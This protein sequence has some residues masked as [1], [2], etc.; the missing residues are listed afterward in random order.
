MAEAAKVVL[1]D[2]PVVINEEVFAKV[3]V[4]VVVPIVKPLYVAPTNEVEVAPKAILV[5]PIVML[6]LVKAVFGMLVKDA[7][8]PENK[9]A[10]TVPLVDNEVGVIL[11]K[12]IVNAGV[13]VAVA[14]VAVIPLLAAAVETEVTVPVP[15][16]L[17]IQDLVPEVVDESTYPL[18]EGF[19]SDGSNPVI[20]PLKVKLPDPVIDPDKVKPLTVPVPETLVTVPVLVV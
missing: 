3:N 19:P 6:E 9:E 4:P 1:K 11:P 10:A 20:A 14:Q 8:D 12:P 13:V 17:G 16:E 2:V 5:V 15:L 18:V 7:P